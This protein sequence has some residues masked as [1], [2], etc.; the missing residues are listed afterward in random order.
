MGI[1]IK[2]AYADKLGA[3]APAEASAPIAVGQKE[4]GPRLGRDGPLSERVTKRRT[5]GA[6]CLCEACAPEVYEGLKEGQ[7]ESMAPKKSP[8][9]EVSAQP[10]LVLVRRLEKC[11][12]CGLRFPQ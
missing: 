7:P 6:R 10:G 3:R 1:V 5:P 8:G 9:R 2:L 11:G 12:L 4:S